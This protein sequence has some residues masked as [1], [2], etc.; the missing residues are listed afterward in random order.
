[1]SVATIFLSDQAGGSSME[2]HDSSA[3]ATVL[4]V[5]NEPAVRTGVAAFLRE[6]GFDVVAVESPDAMWSILETRPDVQVL[7]ADL[8]AAT[9]MDSLELARSVHLRWPSIGLVITSGRVRHLRPADI[10]GNGSFLPRPLP[11]DTLLHKVRV[12]A[13]QSAA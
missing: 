7:V 2:T 11:A 9:G 5:E 8:D 6:A 13:Q 4:L 12:A 10:P 1:V 3:R